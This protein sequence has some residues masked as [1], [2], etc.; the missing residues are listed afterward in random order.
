MRNLASRS[1]D[2]AKEIKKL[3]EDANAKANAGKTISDEMIEGY[4]Q[5][6]QHIS[7]TIQIIDNVSDSSKEQMQ[8]IEQINDAVSM[9]DK[10]TQENA[11]EANN[12]TKIANEV[13]SMAQ[14]LLNDAINKKFN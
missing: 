5:L 11:S 9:L 12:V 7:Q 1:A 2:A 13:D 4:K 8:G 3:V 14:K 6:N 10:V